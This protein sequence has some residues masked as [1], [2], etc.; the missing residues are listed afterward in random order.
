[1]LS[2]QSG[3]HFQPCYGASEEPV[4]EGERQDTGAPRKQ[5]VVLTHELPVPSPNL[6]SDCEYVTLSAFLLFT[7]K[8]MITVPLH[9]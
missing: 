2:P 7:P 9:R 1:M 6:Q 5:A 4:Q 3:Q 8:K